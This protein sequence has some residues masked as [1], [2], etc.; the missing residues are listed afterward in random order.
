[1]T[2]TTSC[3]NAYRWRYGIL[4]VILL[5]HTRARDHHPQQP[6]QVI[7]T[8][9]RDH[10]VGNLPHQSGRVCGGMSTATVRRRSTGSASGIAP[11]P[12]VTTNTW[13]R[14]KHRHTAGRNRNDV[15]PAA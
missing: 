7:Q 1:M 8:V 12:S 4:A 5:R 14:G 6:G 10:R 2:Y 15:P 11:S 3:H 9:D 13:G